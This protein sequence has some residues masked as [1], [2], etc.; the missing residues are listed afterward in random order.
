MI[1]FPSSRPTYKTKTPPPKIPQTNPFPPPQQ[2]KFTNLQ[3]P[4]PHQLSISKTHLQ[5]QKPISENPT[6][7]LHFL[8]KSKSQTQTNHNTNLTTSQNH[9]NPPP[10]SAFQVKRLRIPIPLLSPSHNTEPNHQRERRKKGRK[11][12]GSFIQRRERK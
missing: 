9:K 1:I 4:T 10:S 12:K 2:I 7:S 8:T 3:S 5:N 11:K 6:K